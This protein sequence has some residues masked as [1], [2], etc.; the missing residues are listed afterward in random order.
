VIISAIVVPLD[1]TAVTITQPILLLVWLVFVLVARPFKE[2]RRTIG[3]AIIAAIAC[4]SVVAEY[5][6]I[7]E[8]Q[9]VG[10]SFAYLALVLLILFFTAFMFLMIR[11]KFWL[12]F[13]APRFGYVHI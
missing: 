3:H 12:R 10:N 2:L 8:Y 4:F 9:A 13:I 1:Q 11:E 5:A 6:A 7:K